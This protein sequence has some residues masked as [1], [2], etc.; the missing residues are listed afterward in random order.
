MESVICPYCDAKILNDG[1]L[2]GQTVACST[3]GRQ[4]PKT[5]FFYPLDR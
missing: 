4:F 2:A 1:T 3:R 5:L